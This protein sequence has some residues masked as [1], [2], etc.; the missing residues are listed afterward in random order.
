M[1]KGTRRAGTAT[2][3]SFSSLARPRETWMRCIGNIWLGDEGPAHGNCRGGGVGV[4]GVGPY[5]R[6]YGDVRFQAGVIGMISG[7]PY[8]LTF[9]S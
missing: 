9:G 1:S 8:M 5:G 7:R 4:S 6:M 3:A 2:G